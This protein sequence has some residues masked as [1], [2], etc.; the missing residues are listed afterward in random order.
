MALWCC[1]MFYYEIFIFWQWWAYCVLN[2]K[3]IR[4]SYNIFI[5]SFNHSSRSYRY[6]KN[7]KLKKYSPENWK[8]LF[9]LF[10]FQFFCN[11]IGN[12]SSILIYMTHSNTRMLICCIV[13][14]CTIVLKRVIQNIKRGKKCVS[15][16]LFLKK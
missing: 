6:I 2:K 14:C 1:F 8:L 15:T 10:Q 13:D 7:P 9:F 11:W 5:H 4:S 16:L 12:V 3:N